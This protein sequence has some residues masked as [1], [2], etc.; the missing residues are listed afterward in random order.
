MESKT[1]SRSMERN[2]S[3]TAITGRSSGSVTCRNVCQAFAPSTVAASNGSAGSDCS[4][5]RSSRN[6]NGV[7]CQISAAMMAG[8][9][10]SGLMVHSR[11]VSLPAIQPM[12]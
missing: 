10:R 7:H 4:P 8:Y 1:R 2:S 9:T 12:I 3:A 6:M 11:I 5:A